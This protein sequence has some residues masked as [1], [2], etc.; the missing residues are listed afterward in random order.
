MARNRKGASALAKLTR[1]VASRKRSNPAP[2]KNPG[3]LEDTWDLVLPGFATYAATR[4]AGRVAYKMAVKRSPKLAKHVGA[5]TPSL[6]AGL[7][8]FA[9]HK[10]DRLDKYHHGAVI[11]SCIAAAQSLIQTYVPQVGWLLNDY[12]MN[13]MLPGHVPAQMTAPGPKAAAKSTSSPTA[14]SD[15]SVKED[16]ELADLLGP[17]IIDGDLDIDIMSGNFGGGLAN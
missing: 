11:G 6:V 8:W 3:I 1:N 16:P 15:Y 9:V 12:H 7:T 10:I 17:E 5:L 13:D 14:V 4:L 2:K